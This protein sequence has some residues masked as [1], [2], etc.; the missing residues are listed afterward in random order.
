MTLN[1]LLRYSL[2]TLLLSSLG[3]IH[4]IGQK[5]PLPG[6]AIGGAVASK[7]GEQVAVF[8]G[9]CFWGIETL[10]LQVN[11]V[12]SSTSGYSGGSAET[13]DY[14][15]VGTGSTGHAQ[16]VRV[17][18]D[19]SVVSYGQLLQVYFSAAHD[20]TEL[21]RQGNDVGTQYRAVIFTTNAEQSSIAAAYIKQLDATKVFAKP[22]AT[23][24]EPLKRFFPAEI[25]HQG[26]VL[27][28]MNDPYVV[29]NDLPKIEQFKQSFPQFVRR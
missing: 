4:A 16:V 13:A 6:P 28:N 20:P 29:Q 3:N 19:P 1:T 21:N 7:F 26:F 15:S 23:S 11:G 2:S 18:F 14:K 10:F 8:G 25:Y 17:V 9:G 22:I 12:L 5:A 27:R 24:V